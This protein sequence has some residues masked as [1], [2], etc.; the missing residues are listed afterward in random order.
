M[1]YVKKCLENYYARFKPNNS[2]NLGY[3]TSLI[4]YAI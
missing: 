4:I 1:K 2:V 3:H